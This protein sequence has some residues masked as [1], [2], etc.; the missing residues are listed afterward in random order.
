[1]AKRH[2]KFN[3]QTLTY[4]VI[5]IPFRIRFYRLLR[6]LLIGFLLASVVNLLFSFFFYTPKMYRINQRNNELTLQYGILNDKIK[7]ATSR[8]TELRH[9]DNNVYRQL[10]AADSLTLHGIYTPYP[11][12]K[13]SYMEG[14]LYSEEMIGTW[15]SLDAMTRLLYLESK[16]LDELE[17]LTKSKSQMSEA[18]PA[19]WPI[20]RRFLRGSIGAFGTRVHPITGRLKSH[21]GVDLGSPTGTPVYATGD[22]FVSFNTEGARGYGN[23]IL[24]SHG[25][26]YKTRYAH[27][28]HIDVMPGQRVK[29]GEKIGEVGSTGLSNGPHLH[30]EVIY[31]GVA[32][33]PINYF[34]S[35]MSEAEIEQIIESSQYTTYEGD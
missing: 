14:D 27:L 18:I 7:A 9:R 19:I 12:T 3:P 8:L 21:K 10:F 23:Q 6:K 29:R 28:S 31:R 34:S 30:Y 13:Y 2:Y 24:L 25:F 1:M 22:G 20:N 4:E 35:D 16:S 26:G 17:T 5:A 32:V 11:A 33:N 15:Q